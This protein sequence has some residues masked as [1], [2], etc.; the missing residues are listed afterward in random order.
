MTDDGEQMKDY[1]K[2]KAVL[3]KEAG[4]ACMTVSSAHNAKQ[5]IKIEIEKNV[6]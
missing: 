3:F 2:Y 5:C 4:P 1:G 6:T